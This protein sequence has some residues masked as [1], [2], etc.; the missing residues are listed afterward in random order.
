MPLPFPFLDP[1]TCTYWLWEKPC[2]NILDT[3]SEHIQ[4]SG[5]PSPSP[6]RHLPG[7]VMESSK[8]HSTFLSNQLLQDDGEQVKPV[9]FTNKAKFTRWLTNA[10]G[11]FNTLA[12]KNTNM[13]VTVNTSRQWKN[14][15][16]NNSHEV[17]YYWSHSLFI[18]H[19]FWTAVC[20]TIIQALGELKDHSY[21]G[22]T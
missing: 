11:Y 5:E 22:E 6:A 20:R 4:L 8:G 3:D 7:S 14:K 21:P 10:K 1:R 12:N 9:N 18:K 16:S 17:V 19:L 13:S 2:Y 15:E